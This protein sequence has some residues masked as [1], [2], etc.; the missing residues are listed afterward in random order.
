MSEYLYYL[1]PFSGHFSDK[2]WEKKMQK[3]AVFHVNS[4]QKGDKIMKYG[5]Y[6]VTAGL[7]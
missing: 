5:L 3:K 7:Y 2:K 6:S 4:A 1:K